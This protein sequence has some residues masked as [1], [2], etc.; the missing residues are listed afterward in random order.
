MAFLENKWLFVSIFVLENL[1][2]IA[3]LKSSSLFNG[4]VTDLSPAEVS[5]ADIHNPI[6]ATACVCDAKA[7]LP[8]NVTD[9]K[10]VNSTADSAPVVPSV[11]QPTK[12]AGV[13]VAFL[14]RGYH[15]LENYQSKGG[16][17]VPV[18]QDYRACMKNIRHMLLDPIKQKAQLDIF[19]VTYG[20]KIQDE[21]LA[22]LKPEKHLI[23]NAGA[24]TLKSAFEKGMQMIVDTG[25]EYDHIVIVR[26]DQVWKKSILTWPFWA[27][28]NYDVMLPWREFD[29]LWR[30]HFRVGDCVHVVR[31]RWAKTF[32]EGLRKHNFPRDLHD[33]YRRL[34]FEFGET[35]TIRFLEQG[36]YDSNTEH[37]SHMSNNPLYVIM[38]RKYYGPDGMPP[39]E[40]P[41]A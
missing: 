21:M 33:I 18:T 29:H 4:P 23:L 36:F 6:H 20:S 14:F 3:F 22:D 32:I 19:V 9:A 10:T 11:V 12:P 41:A 24:E 28:Q 5:M 35:M 39:L 2:L 8:A 16:G 37:N 30:D 13:R 34:R 27:D 31:G 25:V 26:F 40:F 1:F 7:I 38:F 15:Y 17:G